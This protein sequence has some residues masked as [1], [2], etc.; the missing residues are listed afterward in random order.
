MI[1]LTLQS[2]EKVPQPL[3]ELLL[4]YES[5][6]IAGKQCNI[7]LNH[8]RSSITSRPQALLDVGNKRE[9]YYN[10]QEVIKLKPSL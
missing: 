7:S 1:C 5:I 2:P 8:Y 9:I 4:S 6:S 10:L 3:P